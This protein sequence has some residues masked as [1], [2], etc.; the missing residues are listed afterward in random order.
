ME[1]HPTSQ[2]EEIESIPDASDDVIK[3]TPDVVKKRA[4]GLPR[5]LVTAFFAIAGY[6][7]IVFLGHGWPFALGVA[8]M[9]IIGVNEFY[10]AVRRQGGEPSDF[11]GIIACLVFQVA[12]LRRGSNGLDPY[13]PA[14]L[15]TLLLATMMVEL[16]KRRSRPIINIGATLLGAI[17]VGWLFSY[18]TLLHGMRQPYLTPPIHGTT[19]GE[20]AVIMVGAI[21][22]AGDGAALFTGIVAGRHKMAPLISPHKTW[23]G[24]VGGVLTSEI[25]S[26]IMGSWLRFPMQ[27][28]AILGV[29]LGC[30]GLLGDLTES[31][32]KRE[33]KVKDFGTMFPGHGGMLDRLD[34][35][36][37]TA[38]FYYYYIS[39]FLLAHR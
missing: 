24:A 17:Y 30:A 6:I 32:L 11:L 16:T 25:V 3:I 5:R 10:G 28:A 8:L 9:S 12:A 19:V 1:F 20:W 38:P 7:L 15:A 21:T 37:F 13:L 23:E 27:H 39:F 18:L 35:V 2:Q 26:L 34:S 36:L 29:A 22:W 33:L 31:A 4:S 14:L